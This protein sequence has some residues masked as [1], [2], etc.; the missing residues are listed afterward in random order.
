MIKATQ[1]VAILA[2]A[3]CTGDVTTSSTFQIDRSD[4]T[5][6]GTPYFVQGSLGTAAPMQTLADVEL[7]M[8]VAL[9]T[10]GRAI[11]VPADQLVPIRLEHDELGMSHVRYAQRAN[12]LPV[13][14]GEVIVHVAMDGAITSVSN[15]TRDA[16]KL[17]ATAQVSAAAAAEFARTRTVN[18]TTATDPDLVYVVTNGDGDI[19]LAWRTDV[20]GTMIHDTVFVDAI[21]GEI[22]ARHPHIH[23]ARSRRIYS[24][25]DVAV[26][27]TSN[28]VGQ[29]GSPPTETIAKIA[30]DNTGTTY[31]CFKMLFNR[32]SYDNAGAVLDSYVHVT[33]NGGPFNNAFWDGQEMVY[34]DGDGTEFTQ[35][36]KALDV[37]AHELSHAVTERSAGLVYQ[38]ESG[39]LNEATSD[40]FGAT[41]EAFKAGAISANTWK[42]G[43]DIYTPGTTGDAM[44][45]MNNPTLD[46]P[47]YNN[48]I[49]SPDYYPE[50]HKLAAG[51]TPDGS[52]DQGYVHFNSGIA[53]LA[54]YLMVH[55]G[56]HPRSKTAFSVQ[57]IGIDKASKI[58]YRALTMYMTANT[59]FAQARSAA[60]MAATDL[61]PGTPAR[62]S[63]GMAFATVGVG[64]PSIADTMPPTIKITAPGKGALVQDGF[65]I[66]AEA[67]DDMGVSRVDFSINGNKVGT[68]TTPPYTFTT[69][70]LGVGTHVIEATA[71]DSVNKSSDSA[72]VVVPDPTCGY[73]CSDDQ[74]CD[75][76]TGQCMD[77]GDEGG[78]CSTSGSSAASSF[79]L[80]SFVA[81]LLRRRRRR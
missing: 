74:I 58:W 1:L 54:F 71:Y 33:Q 29:E 69:S 67:M 19:S 32:D 42:I 3:A 6:S 9:P 40:I 8:S 41:C 7:A 50:R 57:G 37:T 62:T 66:T 12:G 31:D 53:N 34:G 81:L 20:R 68:S 36:V 28:L 35:F 39:A 51:E 11:G 72:M 15:G 30:Y 13:I 48:Q 75:A 24:P 79:G 16:S 38:V 26:E 78:C 52:N 2:L 80:F 23:P 10:I 45:Y 49:Y 70:P 5:D 55:G 64:Q 46:G 27:V 59:T 76:A 65:I 60:E 56:G 47:N 14:G 22:V 18:A 73:K 17:P 63:V 21:S 43:E 44:R 25:A 4:R 61:Y 77:N